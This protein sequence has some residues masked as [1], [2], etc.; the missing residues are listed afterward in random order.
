MTM[1]RVLV[2]LTTLALLVLL[3]VNAL[4]DDFANGMKAYE[5]RDFN[6]ARNVFQALAEAG[7]ARGQYWFGAMYDYGFG[8][9][10][11]HAAALTWYR[12]S[13]EGNNADAQYALGEKLLTGKGIDGNP[14]E[15]MSW[16]RKAAAHGRLGA[17]LMLAIIYRDG[18]GVPA[19]I[20]MAH[21]FASI[22]T[23][24][25]GKI[26]LFERGK[27]AKELAAIMT[28]EQ[29]A[30]SEALQLQGMSELSRLP[31]T[32]TTGRSQGR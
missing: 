31:E 4:A 17:F 24:Q 25:M 14:N 13:A 11:D 8:I 6:K 10:A 21:V 30:E 2:L 28:E 12:K 27:I 3:P 22:D 32:S 29:R 19:D 9:A 20:V 26:D 1:T 7:D 23:A 18:S 15:A 5:A 16:F